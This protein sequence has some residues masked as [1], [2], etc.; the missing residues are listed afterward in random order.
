MNAY[1]VALFLHVTGAAGY[2][3]ALGLEWTALRGIRDAVGAER[4]RE[5]LAT[6]ATARKIAFA[7]ML[8]A[9]VTG[10]YMMRAAWGGAPWLVATVAALLLLILLTAGLAGPRMARLA[11][12]LADE[13][14]APWTLRTLADHPSLR[15]SLHTRVAVALGIVFLKS[16]K[17]DLGGSLVVL[18]VAVLLGLGSA[19]PV[20][21]H[22]TAPEPGGRSPAG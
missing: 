22:A 1:A 6:L 16:A 9:V 10:L 15:I 12:A 5:W 19:L 3:V 20:R 14:P 11:R 7:S 2:F 17:P 4:A 13:A 21:R 8:T 18:G